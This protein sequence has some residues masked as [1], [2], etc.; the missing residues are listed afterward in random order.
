MDAWT[1]VDC[2]SSQKNEK[3]R[4]GKEQNRDH[5]HTIRTCA[6]VQRHIHTETQRHR[7]TEAQIHR[8]TKERKMRRL[9]RSCPFPSFLFLFPSLSLFPAELHSSL[10]IYLHS[11]NN[12][13]VI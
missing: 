12:K 8:H 5:C 11:R 13:W 3:N 2:Q 6:Y 4:G 1:L 10:F 7:D 9:R